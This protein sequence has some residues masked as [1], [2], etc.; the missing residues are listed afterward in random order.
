MRGSQHGAP[1]LPENPGPDPD[2]VYNPRLTARLVLDP[3]ARVHT[4][5]VH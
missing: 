1:K 3:P 2:G 5:Y 4:L